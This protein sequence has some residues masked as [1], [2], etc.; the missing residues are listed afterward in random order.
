MGDLS[1]KMKGLFLFFSLCLLLVAASK[2]DK[3]TEVKLGI[4]NVKALVYDEESGDI[5][6]GGQSSDNPKKGMVVRIKAEGEHAVGTPIE[7]DGPVLSMSLA[8]TSVYC[9][10]ANGAISQINR[11]TE[12]L[13]RHYVPVIEM[14]EV[15]HLV[16][17][18]K[19]EGLWIALKK[20]TPGMDNWCFQQWFRF[21]KDAADGKMD[22]KLDPDWTA[23]S[24][25]HPGPC[26]GLDVDYSTNEV[27]YTDSTIRGRWKALTNAF[28]R[29]EASWSNFNYLERS[30]VFNRAQYILSRTGK[31]D[32]WTYDGYLS[33]GDPAPDRSLQVDLGD[34]FSFELWRTI[35]G[36]EERNSIWVG[37]ED[38]ELVQFVATP[39]QFQQVAGV[40]SKT[41]RKY[42]PGVAVGSTLV[43]V[44]SADEENNLLVFTEL[45]SS[46]VLGDGLD[47]HCSENPD[48]GVTKCAVA[49]DAD[50][51]KAF[52]L[53]PN[54]QVVI[55]GDLRLGPGVV[56]TI[57]FSSSITVKGRVIANGAS[58]QLQDAGGGAGQYTLLDGMVEG[59]F[60]SVKV[61]FFSALKRFFTCLQFPSVSISIDTAIV[62]KVKYSG[63][64]RCATKRSLILY[65]AIFALVAGTGLYYLY[66]RTQKEIEEEEVKKKG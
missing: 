17:H 38:G 21:P 24:G 22:L 3:E 5:W 49:K 48:E 59:Q 26:T 11:G 18:K 25:R 61:D 65:Y 28:V 33:T 53:K 45:A 55:A 52:Q 4:Q 23:F 9:G 16:V 34:R 2:I 66:E 58:L 42:G 50:V 63:L 56:L 31:V 6:A 35:F 27:Y 44:D 12:K 20:A 47:C 1:K 32:S 7:T 41:Q 15:Q 30:I 46:C 14:L 19:E 29:N 10:Q 43:L 8:G 62:A 37:S 60:K 13:V 39:E 36:D 64:K 57:P 51:K 54:T 40:R